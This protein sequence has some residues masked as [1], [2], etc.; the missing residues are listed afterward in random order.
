MSVNIFTAIV[1]GVKQSLNLRYQPSIRRFR[2]TSKQNDHYLKSSS[3]ERKALKAKAHLDH[4]V[5]ES[6]I[7]IIKFMKIVRERV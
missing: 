7:Q 6:E 4:I 2:P 1:H 5:S 3:S